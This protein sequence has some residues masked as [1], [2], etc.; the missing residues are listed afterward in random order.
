MPAAPPSCRA[1]TNRAPPAMRALV[2]WKLPLPTTPNT[3]VAPRRVR[4]VPT[5]S[6]T[7]IQ[8]AG[9]GPPRRGER[10]PGATGAA[11]DRQ[12]EHD[13][14]GALRRQQRQVLQLGEPVLAG[15]EQRRMARERRGERVGRPRGGV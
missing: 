10:P 3:V 4:T 6:L 9:A 13:D 2:T 1:A 8:A 12:R 5:A 14:H 7:R 15:S 11:G